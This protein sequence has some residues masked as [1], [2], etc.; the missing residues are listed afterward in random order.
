MDTEDIPGALWEHAD[1]EH[2]GSLE[3]P[4][5]RSEFILGLCGYVYARMSHIPGTLEVNQYCMHKQDMCKGGMSQD[6]WRLNDMN[7]CWQ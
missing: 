2:L 7:G 1:I 6:V 4:K 3:H 5:I